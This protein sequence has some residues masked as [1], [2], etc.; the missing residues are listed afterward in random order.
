MSGYTYNQW[1]EISDAV[2]G[3]MEYAHD[4]AIEFPDKADPYWNLD[5]YVERVLKAAF[6]READEA[7]RIPYFWTADETLHLNLPKPP[8]RIDVTL[9]DKRGREVYSAKVHRFE[10]ERGECRNK[11]RDYVGFWCSECDAHV[12]DGYFVGTDVEEFKY[13][14]NCG[15][16][17]IKV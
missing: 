9:P 1:K 13:C 17:V 10:S 16:K 6:G 15:R 7:P 14:P 3:A 4:K 12:A 5:E 11:D 2:A 8:E